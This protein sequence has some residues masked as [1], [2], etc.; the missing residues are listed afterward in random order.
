MSRKWLLSLFC[1]AVSVV[2][3]VTVTNAKFDLK[4]IE[5][6]TTV[7]F[8]QIAPT[9]SLSVKNGNDKSVS[10]IV[11]VE[12]LKPSNEAIGAIETATVLK[13]GQHRVS[14]NLPLKSREVIASA[15]TQLLWY[16]LHYRVTPQQGEAAP[17]EGFISLSEITPDLFEL[18]V[19]GPGAVRDGMLYHTRVRAVHPLTERAVKGVYV[20]ASVTLIDSATQKDIVLT[21]AAT[22]NSDGYADI[23]FQLPPNRLID[24]FTL[25]AQGTR[26][27]MTAALKKDMDIALRSHILVSTDKPLYQPGQ[28][29]HVRTLVLGASRHAIPSKPVTIKITDPDDSL[30][31]TAEVNTSRFG[32]ASVDWTIPEHTR[33]GEYRLD[34]STG[35]DQSNYSTIKISR[36]ELPNFV[37][38][39]KSDR[40]YYLAGQDAI[41][42]VRG[43]YLF[44]EPV[45]RGNV[46]VVHVAEQIWN[47]REQKYDIEEREVFI[48]EL[49]L[50]K[51]FS[52]RVPLAADAKKLAERSYDQFHD[53]NF[54][55][56]VTDA[57]TNRTEQRRFNLR[58]TKEPIHVYAMR[59]GNAYEESLGLPLTLYVSTFYADG[60]PARC[61]VSIIDE[62]S[63][64][65]ES[66]RPR[67]IARVKT[68]QYGLAKVSQSRPSDDS[69]PSSLHLKFAAQ[70]KAGN[71]GTLSERFQL[72]DGVG[73]RVSTAKTVFAPG[74]PILATIISSEPSLT[75]SLDVTRDWSIIQSQLVRIRGGRASVLLPYKPEF[76]GE[77]S[78]AAY[79]EQHSDSSPL[80]STRSIMYPHPRDLKLNLQAASRTYKPG[81]RAHVSFKSVNAEGQSV[82]TALGVVVV[83]KAVEE[84]VRSDENGRRYPSFLDDALNLNGYADALGTINRKTLD[85]LDTSQPVPADLDLAAEILL[86]RDSGYFPQLFSSDEYETN[87]RSLFVQQFANQLE[88]LRTALTKAYSAT[89]I[90]PKDESSLRHMLA[91]DGI[92]FE[93][94]KD[95]WGI[96]YKPQFLIARHSDVITL[97]SAGPDKKFDNEDDL[98]TTRMSWPYFRPTGEAIDKSVRSFHERTGG[99]IR[100]IKTLRDELLRLGIDLDT[101]R[102][103]WLKPYKFSFDTNGTNFSINVTTTETGNGSDFSLWSSQIDYFHEMRTKI[104]SALS[105]RIRSSAFPQSRAELRDALMSFG[106]DLDNLRDPWGHVYYVTF[107]TLS[108]YADQVRIEARAD[109]TNGT[110]KRVDIRPVTS[111]VLNVRFRSAGP[112]GQEG[113]SD[114]FDVANFT[115]SRSEQSAA[116]LKPQPRPLMAVLSGSSGAITGTV[117]DVTGAAVSGATVTAAM[118]GTPYEF[119]ATTD[120]DGRYLLRNLRE[121]T[122][123][124][125]VDSPGFKSAVVV[126][127]R[128]KSSQV[129]E[130]NITLEAGGVTETVN[131]SAGEVMALNTSSATFSARRVKDLPPGRPERAP[132]PQQQFFTPRLREFF[133]ETLVW[134]PELTTDTK[135]RAQLD[136]KLADNITTWKMSVIGSTENGEI[137]IAETEIRTFQP[138]F[139]ELDPPQ[140]LTQGDQIS[141][142]VVLRNYLPRK[143]TVDLQIK[144][145]NWFTV[146]TTQKKTEVAARDSSTQTFDIQAISSVTNGKQRVT[147]LGSDF[148]DAIEKPVTVHPDGEEKTTT[149]SDLLR[150]STTLSLDLPA[151]TI[152]N[153]QHVELKIYP[154]LMSHVFESVE[155]IMQRPYGCGEQ[156]ISSTYPSLLI[157]RYLKQTQQ[158]SPLAAKAHRYL[159]EGYQKLLGYQTADGGFTY[160]GRGNADV[161]LTAY[162]IRFLTEAS[163]YTDVD[164][165]VVERARAWLLQ[166]QRS[167][168]SW[169]AFSWNNREIERQTAMLTA[170]VARSLGRSSCTATPT[171]AAEKASLLKSLDYLERRSGE[172]DEPYLIA[173]Y[174][175]AASSACEPARAANANSR[176][177]KLAHQSAGGAYWSLESNTPFYG[178]GVAARVETTALAIQALAQQRASAETQQRSSD[179]VIDRGL[180]FLLREKDRYGIWYSGQ[181]T[182]NV[183]NSLLTLLPMRSAQQSTANDSLEVFVNNHPVKSVQL[184][185]QQ[186]MVGPLMV[187]LSTVVKSGTNTIELKRSVSGALA[188][189]QIVGTY[190][191]PWSASPAVSGSSD[192]DVLRL[193]TRCDKTEARVMELITCRV[194]AERV[195]H[196]GSGMLLAEI[197]LPPGAD[198]DRSA[199]DT[200]I[201]SS[202]W[203]IDSYDVLPDRVIV[204]L[205]P[206]G[207]GS[208]FD[209]KFRPRIAMNAKSPGSIVYDYYNPEA[210]ATIP[211]TRFVIR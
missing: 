167:D 163:D 52:V 160:W 81:E 159:R 143:Q 188:S 41:V 155:G 171:E 40:P 140:I 39:V 185:V 13:S 106:I 98:T 70:D 19:T 9:V 62:D 49:R 30:A 200:A 199:L 165:K 197:G 207:G 157:L 66:E 55:A 190:W 74:E 196:R 88:P 152:S 121:G 102:D 54:T 3:F 42:T 78:L 144:P 135:G 166:R 32:I 112:D 72:K 147:A 22:T 146:N 25:S 148:S 85:N 92:D 172:M 1:L 6:A 77:L 96:S 93:S 61:N 33:L 64:S 83:D 114:D 206:R 69:D 89:L 97:Q 141:L 79:A 59:P 194:K 192:S 90:Y 7:S 195:G 182:I 120:D 153:S 60:T 80:L 173:S 184:P 210:R 10:A 36:H 27:S 58:V 133:P 105:K 73:I 15:Q 174:S 8:Q 145:E 67:V 87:H 103:R 139:A 124:L 101:L 94:L 170:L 65:D 57:S 108:F 168:G 128:M 132:K 204:Y 203:A 151:E 107:K 12:L 24:D 150:E 208:E 95:P 115:G 47:Q 154:N 43:D 186:V 178:W 193:D 11:R 111:L 84:R 189:V 137:G 56:Y 63:D 109:G 187:D 38:N 198:V 183:L 138:F 75:V 28:T 130:L 100:D 211:A 180:L 202:N 16:R 86:N 177:R 126:D 99:Y 50:D 118:T 48:G 91:N 104:D 162:A 134:Q 156:T 26:G 82:E 116:D 17:V 123:E 20:D 201:K 161:A 37:V 2:L 175:L 4:V 51:T 136:F 179:D 119:T 46:R 127:V 71:K 14:I 169:P 131:V 35:E 45:L 76:K 18:R 68:N 191:V 149:A 110:R 31:F 181:A 117:S 29:I 53:L 142:P 129:L 122:Y 176:L 44:G 209:L 21:N 113:T 5:T 205:W 34:V 125:R 158:E 23:R 164:S